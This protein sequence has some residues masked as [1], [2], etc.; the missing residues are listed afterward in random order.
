MK[1]LRITIIMLFLVMSAGAVCAADNLSCDITGDDN[2][3]VLK[4]VQDDIYSAGEQP[5]SGINSQKLADTANYKFNTEILVVADNRKVLELL[6]SIVDNQEIL[7]I[8]GAGSIGNLSS[9]IMD[10]YGNY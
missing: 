1:I 8:Q 10:K 6:P 3:H 5:I 9:L 4:A 2:S 7:L